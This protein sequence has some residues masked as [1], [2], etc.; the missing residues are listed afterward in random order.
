MVRFDSR[1][2]AQDAVNR[3]MQYVYTLDQA[4]LLSGSSRVIVWSTVVFAP[5]PAVYLNRAALLLAE[6]LGV[7]M[8]N[9]QMVTSDQ[10]PEPRTLLLG[11]L[12][13]VEPSSRDKVKAPDE[14]PAVEPLDSLSGSADV[15]LP[16][17]SVN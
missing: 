3:I 16:T 2:A 8:P 13:D 12:K 1:L 14:D 4:E 10:L 7:M 15:N 11:Q 6:R 17:G 5:V 9:R